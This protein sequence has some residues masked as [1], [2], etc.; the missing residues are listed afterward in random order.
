MARPRRARSVGA[1]IPEA[2]MPATFPA[3]HPSLPALPAPGRR[4]AETPLPSAA[5]ALLVIGSSVACGVLAAIRAWQLAAALTLAASAAAALAAFVVITAVVAVALARVDAAM[6][7]RP[8]R[9]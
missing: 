1:T 3:H 8:R 6:A 9:R 2:D 5:A 7:G 4:H